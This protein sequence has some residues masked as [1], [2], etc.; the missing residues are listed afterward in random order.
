MQ[1]KKFFAGYFQCFTDTSCTGDIVSA[2]N[3][4]ECC[5]ETNDGLAFSDGGACTL[6]IGDSLE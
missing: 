1:V 5:V 3:E 6:C 2:G 4:K